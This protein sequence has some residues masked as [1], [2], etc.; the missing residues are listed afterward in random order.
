MYTLRFS[1]GYTRGSGLEEPLAGVQVC[2]VGEDG[3]ALLHRVAP[4]FDPEA[5]QRELDAI[6]QVQLIPCSQSS[7]NKQ[8]RTGASYCLGEWSRYRC[9]VLSIYPP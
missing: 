2:M 8:H 5:L 6:S 7:H 9:L 1:T 4:F 3:S